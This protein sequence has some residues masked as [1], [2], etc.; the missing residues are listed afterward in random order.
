MISFALEEDQQ[1]VQETVRKFAAE[2]LRPKLRELEAHGVPDALRKQ[3]HE[4][5]LGLVDVP[6]SFGGMGG[7]LVTAVIVQEE[8]AH[9]DPGA[10]VALWA[11]HLAAQALLTLGD[12]AQKQRYLGRFADTAGWSRL[13]AV[14]YAEPNAPL[15]GFATIAKKDGDRYILSG[16]KAFVVNGGSADVTIVFAQLDGQKGWDGAAAFVVEAGNPGLRAGERHK[17]LGLEAVHA[18]EVTLE[19]CAVDASARLAG[20]GE[21][22]AAANRMFARAGLYNA[23]RQVGLA[24]AAYEYALEYTQDRK[25]FGKPVAHFQ[26]IAF[27][28]AEMA[29]EVEAAR[30]MVWRAATELERGKIEWVHEAVAHA[31]DAAWRVADHG[32][33][34]LGGAGYIKDYPVEKWLRDTKALALFGPTSECASLAVAADELGHPFG[35]GLPSSAIQPFFT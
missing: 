12:D 17:L 19:A 2:A 7:S 29:T 18:A 9:G 22:V 15:E 21:F 30:W 34:L 5:G 14:A 33:Q 10:A 20:G 28:L 1:M 3:F 23:A 25:A 4:L 31:H 13:G 35:G 32:V 24:R 6:E 27:T 16:K 11:P 26:S 8:L